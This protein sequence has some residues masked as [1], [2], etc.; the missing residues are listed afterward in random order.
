M[1]IR[2]QQKSIRLLSLSLLSTL[3]LTSPSLFAQVSGYNIGDAVKDT[4]VAK[5]P[6]KQVVPPTP[7]IIQEEEAPLSLADGEKIAIRDFRVEG[8]EFLDENEVSA[9]LQ[10][11]RNRELNIGEIKQAANKITVY[12]REKGYLVARAYVPKQDI[13]DGV[14]VIK[15]IAGKYGK[16]QMKNDSLVKDSRLQGIFDK[17]KEN[18]TIVT[19]EGL[20]RPMLL[21]NDTPGARMPLVSIS[22]GTEPG[23]SDF[24][25]ETEAAERVQGY[26]MIDNYGSRF[27]GENRLTSELYINSPFG[28]GDR[29]SLKG[30]TTKGAGLQNARAAYAFPLSN[31]GLNLE[32]A[33]SKTTYKLGDEY[34]LL[35]ASGDAEMI[36]AKLSYPIKRTR[37]DSIYLSL[38]VA[39]KQLKDEYFDGEAS[40]SKQENVATLNLQRET[41]GSFF[42]FSS[43]ANLNIGAS[44]GHLNFD[45]KALEAASDTAGDFSK[46][47]VSFFGNLAF[48]DQ[49]SLETSLQLQDS[50]GN[51]LDG[52]EQ[53]SASG[54]DGIKSYPDGVNGDKGYL[55]GAELKYN[56]TPG[57][58][59]EHTFGFFAN[60]GS[61]KLD[62]KSYLYVSDNTLHTTDRISISDIGLAYNLSSKKFFGRLQ[63]ARTTGNSDAISVYNDET[64]VQAL[65]G[66]R[67]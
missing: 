67:F 48:S 5:P 18:S 6:V 57:A 37:E 41:Y 9:L 63:V 35:D 38:D 15:V 45:D 44:F 36:N 42:G 14:L 20:E 46:L 30:T 13:Q 51:N 11:Y 52:V 7:V 29:I 50:L 49:W 33:A 23:T 24:M 34:A 59:I 40:I 19:K 22:A 3:T 10:P 1:S 65:A 8:A 55:V 54:A 28:I 64:K 62:G 25:I 26:A 43:Y 66:L 60:Y 58:D 39:N 53:I 21:V 4:N 12:A 31:D 16:F 47:N 56:L 27:T 61:V 32:V 17:V 2:H